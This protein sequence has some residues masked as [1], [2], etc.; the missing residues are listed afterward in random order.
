MNK[1]EMKKEIESYMEGKPNWD[2]GTMHVIK[3]GRDYVHTISLYEGSKAEKI[4]IEDFYNEY[5]A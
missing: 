2:I 5:V 3:I 1:A 4:E